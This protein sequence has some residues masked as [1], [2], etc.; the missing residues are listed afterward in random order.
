MSTILVNNIKSYTGT[1]VTISGSNISVTGNTT[2]GDNSGVDVITINGSITASNNMT[3]SG[4]IFPSVD[5]TYDLGSSAYQWNTLHATT[6]SLARIDVKPGFANITVSG[7]TIFQDD[8]TIQGNTNFTTETTVVTIVTASFGEVSSSILPDADNTYDLGSA[9]LQWNVA[10]LTTASV[11]HIQSKA[12]GTVVVSGSL[13]PLNDD[14]HDLGS[15]TREWKDVYSDG[16]AYLSQISASALPTS[17]AAAISGEL[18][19]LSGSQIFSSS[20]FTPTA[21]AFMD[22]SFSAS[23]FVFL[24]A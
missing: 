9:A 14:K 18:Y 21:G 7:S 24:K 2:L 5:N 23:L 17:T 6:A 3:I 20:V 8:V 19:T 22:A 16:V 1:T 15:V 10:H 13:N 4:S 12:G 11:A